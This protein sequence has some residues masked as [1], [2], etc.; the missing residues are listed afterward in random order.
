RDAESIGADPMRIDALRRSSERLSLLAHAGPFELGGLADAELIVE[1]PAGICQHP[2]TTG[3]I[4][5]RRG[6]LLMS[7]FPYPVWITGGRI[8]LEPGLVRF[9]GDG[10]GILTPGGGSG[11]VTGQIGLSP[12]GQRGQGTANVGVTLLDDEPNDLL[13]AAIP[14]GPGNRSGIVPREVDPSADPNVDPT[15]VVADV[16]AW[17]GRLRAQSA[18]FLEELQLRGTLSTALTIR[19]NVGEPV[20][21]SAIVKFEDGSAAPTPRIGG[22]MAEVGLVWPPGFTVEPLSA[23]LD[24]SKDGLLVRELEGRADDA[25][26]TGTADMRF[27]PTLRS[28][29]TFR[30]RGLT[31]DEYLLDLLPGSTAAAARELWDRYR[32]SGTF[33][34]TI[35]VRYDS[36]EPATVAIEAEPRAVEVTLPNGRARLERLAGSLTIAHDAIAFNGLELRTS[37]AGSDTGVIHLDGSYGLGHRDGALAVNGRWTDAALESGIVLEA[38]DLLKLR[39]Q[40]ELYGQMRPSGRFDAAFAYRSATPEDLQSYRLAVDPRSVRFSVEDTPIDLEI[41][42]E[43]SIVFTPGRIDVAKM[44]GRA[45]GGSFGVEG[46]FTTAGALRGDLH[47]DLDVPGLTPAVRALLPAAVRRALA[48][49]NARVDG[50]L[51]VKGASITLQRAAETASPWSGAFDGPIAFAG[52]AFDAGLEYSGIDGSLQMRASGGGDMPPSLQGAFRLS[53]M[54]ARERKV[55]NVRG[56]FRLDADGTRFVVP[57]LDG[58]IGS[59]VVMASASV[60]LGNESSYSASVELVDAPMSALVIESAKEAAAGTA[61]PAADRDRAGTVSARLGIQGVREHND[62]LLGRGTLRLRDAKVATMPVVLRVLQLAALMLP[63]DE[64]LKEADVQFYINGGQLVFEKLELECSMLRL[65]GSGDMTVPGL[66][67]DVRFVPRG[68]LML[69]S[70]I[71]GGLSDR[72]YAIE[73]TGPLNDPDSQIVPLPDVIQSRRATPP[74]PTG[75]NDPYPTITME[76][77]R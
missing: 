76:P 43:S 17:P 35:G 48:S 53:S 4:D 49:V 15:A 22:A 9:E 77:A 5:I 59:G 62:L 40:R 28:D 66:D 8:A 26:L 63:L 60:G 74:S 57:R 25:T 70:D 29:S 2:V 19:R 27:S 31:F 65:V 36:P 38:M 21:W 54:L 41:D 13:L 47:L 75:A 61:D 42:D 46:V 52:G 72:L 33:D 11:R 7:K 45:D 34:A 64:S 6:G 23:V 20:D 14:I 30:F 18:L 1:R 56:E 44:T 12:P 24:L 55:E 67:L 71:V 10:I 51:T 58:R 3:T 69:M 37:E 68:R 16:A 50:R 39:E 32:P 73:V